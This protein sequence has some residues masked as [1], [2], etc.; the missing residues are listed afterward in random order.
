[1]AT[2]VDENGYKLLKLNEFT[3]YMNLQ[4]RRTE[5]TLH[6]L[7]SQYLFQSCFLSGC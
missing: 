7:V 5:N 6:H 2:A 4:L 3:V 1:M